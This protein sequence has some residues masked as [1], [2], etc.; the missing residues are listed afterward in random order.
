MSG[1]PARHG[2]GVATVTAAEA[3]GRPSPLHLGHYDASSRARW[4][5]KWRARLSGETRAELMGERR[6]AQMAVIGD[7]VARG[8]EVALF[9]RLYAL[10][11]RQADLLFRAGVLIRRDLFAA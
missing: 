10:D 9:A 8:E 2:G 1:L 11:E 6:R 7:A 4:V 3:L 5:A